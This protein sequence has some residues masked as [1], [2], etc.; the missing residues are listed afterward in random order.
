[1]SGGTGKYRYA[2]ERRH[3]LTFTVA[4]SGYLL[5]TCAFQLTYGKLYNLFPTKWVFL[6]AIGL[7]ELGS[8][9][10]GA[11]PSSVGFIMGRVVQ[12]IGAGG[13]FSG[14]ILI[15]AAT[16]PLQKRPIVNGLLGSMFAIASVAGPL[17]GGAFTDKVT[18]RLCFYINLPFGLVTAIC[19]I[20]FLSSKDGRKPDFD[21]PLK[22]KLRQLDTVGLLAFIP[23]IV[24][25]LLAL[26]WGGA[27]YPWSNWRV[28]L[29]F[30]VAGL[31]LAAFAGVQYW[32]GD[33]ATVPFSVL[34]KRTVW[35]CGTYSFFLFGGFLA[36]NYYLPIWFQA[37]KGVSA[38]Q[39]GIHILPS[40]LSVVVFSLM[41]GGLVTWLGYYSWACILSTVLAAVVRT[42]EFSSTGCWLILLQG[43][44]L[45][46]TFK[47]TTGSAEWIG[48]QVIFGAGCGV[49]RCLAT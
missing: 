23:C 47:P 19:V 16:T 25:F 2:F 34:R 35:A 31:T 28:I 44:G 12:G 26:T 6:I 7:F 43:A 22:Q 32:Q 10:C 49:V 4:R 14:A 5:T 11:T 42:V 46:T 38:V 37:I 33:S 20:V 1:M 9:V 15:I 21:L 18:W 29:L 45:F 39:S 41:S 17:M 40:I 3:A 13:I 24:S 36:F 48:Y 8:L 30:V 27:T